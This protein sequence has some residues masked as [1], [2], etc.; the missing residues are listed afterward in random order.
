M[1][2][3][4]PS[5]TKL[6]KALAAFRRRDWRRARRLFEQA[7]IEHPTATGDYHLGLLEWRGLGGPRDV[8]AAVD[9]FARASEA[10]H[11]AAQTAYGI[12][13]QAGIGAA[14]DNDAARELFRLAASAGDADG[15]VQLAM[16]SE[17]EDARSYLVR[18]SELGN[19]S[20]MLHLSSMLMRDEPVEALAWLYASVAISGDDACRKRAAALARE[21]SA[22]EIEAAQK[23]G[24]MY[25]KDIHNRTRARVRA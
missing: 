25:A 16:M 4:G 18:A 1:G 11:P 5:P 6:E 22:K 8:R 10:G 9:C 14:K 19:P 7:D 21:M 20:A 15:M 23:A 13:L 2:L 12:A 24:R 3:F 17:P